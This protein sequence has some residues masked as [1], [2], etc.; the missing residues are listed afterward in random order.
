MSTIM[1]P[2]IKIP[3]QVT[4]EYLRNHPEV[5]F[6]F[7][8]N[9]I[10]KGKAGGALL[11]DEPNT[12]G[13]VTKR[14]PGSDDDDFYWPEEY[15]SVYEEEV[16][17]LKKQASCHPEKLFLVSKLGSGLANRFRIF[18]K[19]IEPNIKITFKNFSNVIFLW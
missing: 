10:R 19:V 5:V 14:L 1:N 9:S 2:D 4:Q 15:Q 18:E 13:F 8:D 17:R 16:R 6:V 12:H 7:G 11:R 3:N